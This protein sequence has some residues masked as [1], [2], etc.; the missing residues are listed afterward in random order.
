MLFACTASTVVRPLRNRM[1]SGSNPRP[2]SKVLI[3]VSPQ[4][5]RQQNPEVSSRYCRVE[6]NK[7]PNVSASAGEAET[8]AH[9]QIWSWSLQTRA[10]A[11]RARAMHDF[12]PENSRNPARG[13]RA[14]AMRQFPTTQLD[15]TKFSTKFI[16]K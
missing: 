12:P 15:S 9:G 6:R 2:A 8:F 11:P 3:F 16:L 10:S 5:Q 13:Q 14:G 7:T 4:Y 1:V